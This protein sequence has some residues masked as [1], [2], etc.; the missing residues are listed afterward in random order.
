MAIVTGKDDVAKGWFC[1]R[2]RVDFEPLYSFA[3]Y[4]PSRR[5]ASDIAC[6]V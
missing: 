1:D 3:R 4:P 2:S 6:A 5:N